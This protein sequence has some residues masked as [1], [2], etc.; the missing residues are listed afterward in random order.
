MEANRKNQITTRAF[1]KF[2]VRYLQPPGLCDYQ[3]NFFKKKTHKSSLKLMKGLVR[4]AGNLKIL[5]T[6]KGLQM[7]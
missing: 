2:Y 1:S 3:I 6:T 7:C 4:I 5:E